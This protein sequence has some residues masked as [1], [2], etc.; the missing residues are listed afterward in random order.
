MTVEQIIGALVQIE[1][2]LPNV[3]AAY[4]VAPESV[5]ALPAFVNYLQSGSFEFAT[6]CETRDVHVIACDF[7]CSRGT[8]QAA[9]SYARPIIAAFRDA[10]MAD[11][12]LGGLC[13]TCFHEPLT[14]EYRAEKYGSQ[15]VLVVA[16]RVTCEVF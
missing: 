13:S 6:T 10:L 5:A 1:Q 3:K 4:A 14:Y 8:I 7:V 2:G 16:F 12:T 11:V 15:E 9:E